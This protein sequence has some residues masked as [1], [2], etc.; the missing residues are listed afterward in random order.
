MLLIRGP[1]LWSHPLPLGALEEWT[2]W[3]SLQTDLIRIRISTRSPR[4]SYVHLILSITF[5]GSSLIS[6]RDSKEVQ[7]FPGI[8]Y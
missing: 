2:A 6:R 8:A 1:H 5:L 7:T 3:V 4:G